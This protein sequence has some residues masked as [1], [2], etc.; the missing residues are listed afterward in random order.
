MTV[1]T[2]LAEPIYGVILPVYA[3]EILGSA[4]QL[5]FIFGALG[6]GSIVGNILY[7]AIVDRVP[8]SAILS[9]ETLSRFWIMK[10]IS[11]TTA[12]RVDITQGLESGDQ[13]QVV[14]P[15]LRS[16]DAVIVN[17]AYGLPDTARVSLADPDHE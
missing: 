5:G 15:E 13:V 1:G 9:D 12:V 8:R 3:N 7:L 17:G 14:V 4:A 2:L 10:M 11:E 6:A 16:K